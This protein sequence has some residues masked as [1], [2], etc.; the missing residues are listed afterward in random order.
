MKKISLTDIII[1]LVIIL[2]L[3]VGFITFKKIRQTAGKQIEATEKIVFQVFLRGVTLT[4]NENPI[5]KGEKTFIT[6]RNVPYSDVEVLDSKIDTKKIVIPD[7]RS[8]GKSFV[9]EDYSQYGMY[10]IVVTL[11]DTAQITKDGAVVG[12]NKIKIGLPITLEG[13]SYKLNGV[14]SNIGLYDKAK[15]EQ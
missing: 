7:L 6:I 14:V 3:A 2:S 11:T 1:L 5:K 8:N 15:N 13:Q 9:Y 4:T 10:D 12:G